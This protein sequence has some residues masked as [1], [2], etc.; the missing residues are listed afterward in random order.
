MQAANTTGPAAKMA[1]GLTLCSEQQ[2]QP[3]AFLRPPSPRGRCW[4]YLLSVGGNDAEVNGRLR[5]LGHLPCCTPVAVEGGSVAVLRYL[6]GGGEATL[7][8]IISHVHIIHVHAV[9]TDQ[10]LF[11]GLLQHTRRRTASAAC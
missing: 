2:P 11:I 5:L 3:V 9:P 6:I 10:M 8:F 7:E 1:R 4:D